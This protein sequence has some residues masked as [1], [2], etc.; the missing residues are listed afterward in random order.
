M[1]GGRRPDREVRGA[2]AAAQHG[3]LFRM[4]LRLGAYGHMLLHI[5][6]RLGQRNGSVLMLELLHPVI[7]ENNHAWSIALQRLLVDGAGG[8][9]HG[10]AALP[11]VIEVA[12]EMDPAGIPGSIIFYLSRFRYDRCPERSPF[13]LLPR[14]ITSDPKFTLVATSPSPVGDQRRSFADARRST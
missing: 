12:G 5:G 1:P 14:A 13:E 7:R 8:K 3:V 11:D 9:D 10:S 6:K 4:C 2:F